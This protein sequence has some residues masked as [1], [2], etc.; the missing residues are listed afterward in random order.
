MPLRRSSSCSC[1]CSCC[2]FSSCCYFSTVGVAPVSSMGLNSSAAVRV[3]GNHGPPWVWLPAASAICSRLASCHWA[4]VGSSGG[5][6]FGCSACSAFLFLLGVHLNLAGGRHLAV[7]L[8]AHGHPAAALV[9]CL[10]A[11]VAPSAFAAGVL[12]EAR[13]R[14][15]LRPLVHLVQTLSCPSPNP[16]HQTKPEPKPPFKFNPTGRRHTAAAEKA[17]AT[18]RERERGGASTQTGAPERDAEE[19][20]R[21]CIQ[22]SSRL[23]STDWKSAAGTRRLPGSANLSAHLDPLQAEGAASNS[24]LCRLGLGVPRSCVRYSCAGR[25]NAGQLFR[26]LQCESRADLWAVFGPAAFEAD[27]VRRLLA[28][29]NEQVARFLHK[30]RAVLLLFE[31]QVAASDAINGAFSAM[32]LADTTD[33][34]ERRVGYLDCAIQLLDAAV[35]AKLRQSTQPFPPPPVSTV[36]PRAWEAFALA[37]PTDSSATRRAGTSAEQL[38]ALARLLRF[39][40]L[41]CLLLPRVAHPRHQKATAERH[42]RLSLLSQRSTQ[43]EQV[44]AA[45]LSKGHWNLAT[46]IIRFCKLN[47]QEILVETATN[48]ALHAHKLKQVGDFLDVVFPRAGNSAASSTFRPPPSSLPAA[49]DGLTPSSRSSSPPASPCAAPDGS[50]GA[51]H[52]RIPAG[53]ESAASSPPSPV[54]AD[55]NSGLDVLPPSSYS[56]S[57]ASL[58]A[59]S[60]ASS[61]AGGAWAP[62]FP[63]APHYLPSEATRNHEL[64]DTLI[65]NCMNVWAIERSLGKRAA[66]APDGSSPREQPPHPKNQQLQLQ[67]QKRPLPPQQQ[68]QQHNQ[69]RPEQP[70]RSDRG[71]EQPQESVRRSFSAAAAGGGGGVVD[72]AEAVAGVEGNEAA[73]G[74]FASSVASDCSPSTLPSVSASRPGL[75]SGGKSQHW[76]LPLHSPCDDANPSGATLVCGS[77]GPN[78]PAACSLSA[79]CSFASSAAPSALAVGRRAQGWRH[80]QVGE[81]LLSDQRYAAGLIQRLSCPRKRL[82]G[83]LILLRHLPRTAAAVHLG[84]AITLAGAVGIQKELEELARLTKQAVVDGT[85]NKT[86]A[87]D[88]L[89]QLAKHSKQRTL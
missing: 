44:A 15:H 50:A 28:G 89:K 35:A 7:F 79:S 16:T 40:R 65:I 6:C 83:C 43:K 87:A 47:L 25:C 58:Q 22:D 75:A 27:A 81:V 45:L 86:H 69:S 72:S 84:H 73:L 67:E 34:F 8:L 53:Y 5:D 68:Q 9:A 60:A 42:L 41:F 76:T 52:A 29:Y 3:F 55:A 31:W 10:G 19:C 23:K 36:L 46:Q 74:V 38:T 12:P 13:R 39:E 11:A 4:R 17:S 82:D 85:I 62:V 54:L 88:L 20:V 33:S 70:H 2:S 37:P 21:F 78:P 30:E 80:Y 24:F 61:R 77:H 66:V 71:S 63:T 49:S 1:S 56:P 18:A 57:S 51:R 59:T 14:G 64:L 48:I 32:R 26:L